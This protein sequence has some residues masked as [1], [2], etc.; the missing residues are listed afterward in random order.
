MEDLAEGMAQQILDSAGAAFDPSIHIAPDRLNKNGTFR[1]RKIRHAEASDGGEEGA[2]PAALG[3]AVSRSVFT[4]AVVLGGENWKPEP[5]EVEALDNAWVS[6][7]RTRNITNIPPEVLLVSALTA[8]AGK[9]LVLSERSKLGAFLARFRRSD[10]RTNNRNYG[11][12]QDQ[13]GDAASQ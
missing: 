10:A 12:G 13:S 4:I 5:A 8:Y 6:Y 1:K 7:F 11:V 9:R 3:I 2:D